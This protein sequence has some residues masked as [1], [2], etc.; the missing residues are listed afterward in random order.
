RRS[1][2]GEVSSFSELS[3]DVGEESGGE[4][5]KAPSSLNLTPGATTR[6][7][8]SGATGFEP[9]ISTLTGRH[10][11]TLHH[12]HNYARNDTI[13]REH[14]QEQIGRSSGVGQH[15]HIGIDRQ[16]CQCPYPSYCATCVNAFASISHPASMSS[17]L[18][19][20]CGEMRRTFP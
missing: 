11:R 19:P 6:M 20:R 18:I 9:A 14:C 12:S 15:G 8:D 17:P 16:S 5:Q 7:A 10:V 13:T 2:P 3:V 1:K 4:K